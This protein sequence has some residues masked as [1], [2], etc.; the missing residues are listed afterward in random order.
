MTNDQLAEIALKGDLVAEARLCLTAEL[1]GR[2]I[3]DLEPYKKLFDERDAQ[4]AAHSQYR[5]EKYK[6]NSSVYYKAYAVS[7]LCMALWGAWEWF[8]GNPQY[9]FNLFV[10]IV[11][12]TPIYWLYIK[13][14][15][16]VVK[17]ILR[18]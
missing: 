15:L 3:T 13:L 4:I 18:L 14:R 2:G 16:F 11:I 10:G 5:Y 8:F 12:L 6:A 7:C 17:W 1:S 9:A